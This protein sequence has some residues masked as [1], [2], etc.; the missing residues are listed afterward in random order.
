[1]NGNQIV[2]AGNLTRD[3]EFDHVGQ[4]NSPRARFGVASAH[5]FRKGDGEWE[6]QT[7]FFNVVVWRDLAE[8]VREVLSKGMKVIV[9]GRLEIRSYDKD[10]GTKGQAVDVVADDVA[11]S[12]R[13]V[14]SVTRRPSKAS[15]QAAPSTSSDSSFDDDSLWDE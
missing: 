7:S 9:T 8:Q 4:A 15:S 3:P 12:V 2:V 13:G 11:V 1:M 5:S 10:D 6:E 14:S